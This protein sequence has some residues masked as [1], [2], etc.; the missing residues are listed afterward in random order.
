[1]TVPPNLTLTFCGATGTVT[2]SKFLLS[3]GRRRLLI[4]CGLFQGYK[5]LR[6]RNWARP[7]FNPE[8]VAAVVLT[9]AHIDHSGYLPLL[10]RHGFRGPILCSEAT[11]ALLE[12]MLPDAAHLQEEE[13][14][15]ANRHGFSRHH[16]ALPLYTH[17]DA[18]RALALVKGVGYHTET[19]LPGGG[20]FLLLP[21]GHILGSA[22]ALVRAGNTRILFSGDIGRPND[23]LMPAPEQPP[24]ADYVVVESTYGDRLHTGDGSAEELAQVVNRTAARG[25]VV[26]IP[27]FAVGRAQTLM[28]LLHRLCAE[29]RIPEIPIYLN[30]PMAGRA[31]LAYE[32]F[33]RELRISHTELEQMFR[34]VRLVDS[35]DDSIRLNGRNGPMIIISASGMATGG[36]VLH[37]LARFAPDARNTILFAGFQAGG[38]RGA[39]LVG[40]EK[41]VRIHGQMV[42]VNAEVQMLDNLSS[43]ADHGEVI[44]WLRGMPAAPRKAFIVHGE[45]AAAD[46]MRQHIE[47]ELRWPCDVP[48]YLETADL[49]LAA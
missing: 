13:A 36:R 26:V 19:E 30:S 12:I 33:A 17:E 2:G 11:R 18:R 32:R 44:R 28:L 35:A 45:P 22:M 31:S 10:V 7:P 20:T 15:Y 27:A 29:R 24:Q 40:G 46:H 14:R 37:H 4:D 23:V 8:E 25:G 43:H 42:P 48:D 41:Q 3:A 39:A 6:L 1:M 5:Q 47:R 49:A 38:T 34:R 16:P 21:N 9:H